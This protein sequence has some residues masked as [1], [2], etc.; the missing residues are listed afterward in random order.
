MRRLRKHVATLVTLVVMLGTFILCERAGLLDVGCDH[1]IIQQVELFGI[2][3][4]FCI[5]VALFVRAVWLL[6][7][8]LIFENSEPCNDSDWMGM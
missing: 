7:T 2:G 5:G 1:E 6:I 3:I 4:A 8:D